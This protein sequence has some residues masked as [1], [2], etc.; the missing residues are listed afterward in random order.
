MNQTM[1][2]K[3]MV[4]QISNQLEI[5]DNQEDFRVLRIAEKL[6]PRVFSSDEGDHFLIPIESEIKY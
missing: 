1:S 3:A 6:N 4:E 5:S 2:L